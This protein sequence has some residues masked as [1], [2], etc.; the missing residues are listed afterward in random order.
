MAW[1]VVNGF[2]SGAED[3]GAY[4]G[5]DFL[6]NGLLLAGLGW[7]IPFIVEK[8]FVPSLPDSIYRALH[9]GLK[10]GLR[11]IEQQI[12]PGLEKIIEERGTRQSNCSVL[13][14]RIAALSGTAAAVPDLKLDRVLMAAPENEL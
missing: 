12:Q 8:V 10:N 5:L 2:I 11:Q 14:E 6:V 3:R 13:I 7:L 9:S 4:V 1:R